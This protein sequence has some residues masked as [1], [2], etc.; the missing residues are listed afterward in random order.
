MIVHPGLHLAAMENLNII[1]VRDN[2]GVEILGMRLWNDYN[3]IEREIYFMTLL[4]SCAQCSAWWV[5]KPCSEA[6]EV[7]H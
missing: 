7:N 4:Y 2:L 1:T 3:K 5:L 6:N